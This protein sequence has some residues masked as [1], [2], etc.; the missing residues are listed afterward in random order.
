MTKSGASDLYRRLLARYPSLQPGPFRELQ[1]LQWCQTDGDALKRF[2]AQPHSNCT[3]SAELGGANPLCHTCSLPGYAAAFN[4]SAIRQRLGHCPLP[5][6]QQALCAGGQ[7]L[8]DRSG[9]KAVTEGYQPTFTVDGSSQYSASPGLATRAATLLRA[10]SPRTKVI[11][12]LR[13]PAD[14]GR[15][16]YNAKLTTECGTHGCE[17]GGVPGRVHVPPYQT[18]V[19]RELQ[20]LNTST[21]KSGL[22]LLLAAAGNASAGRE[23]V[24]TLEAGWDA[25]WKSRAASWGAGPRVFDHG[26]TA[27]LYSLAGVYTPVL[28]AWAEKFV[29]PGAPMLVVHSE[30][31]FTRAPEL[32]DSLFGTFLFGD[33]AGLGTWADEGLGGGSGG[34]RAYGAKASQSAAQRCAVYD[35]LKPHNAALYARIARLEKEGKV[36]MGARAADTGPLWPRP[37]ECFPPPGQDVSGNVTGAGDYDYAVGDYISTQPEEWSYDYDYGYQLIP[38]SPPGAS[39]SSSGR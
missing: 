32:L 19:D 15:A 26:P 5:L 8:P 31:Y 6:Q 1:F 30:G 36:Q 14:L 4:T 34:T 37:R 23:A 12:L 18:I 9:R 39:S 3:Q 17:G 28:N 16:M 13:S 38:S 35:L 7:L 22:A 2:R 21:G 11:L 24:Q 27:I 10:I 25:Y 33:A 20:Y 29:T